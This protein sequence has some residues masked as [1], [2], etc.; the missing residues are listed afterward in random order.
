MRFLLLAFFLAAALPA[1]AQ[2]AAAIARARAAIQEALRQRPDDATLHFFMAR[3]DAASGD[4]R[5]ATEELA[6]AGKL[7]DGFLPAKPLGFE[8]VWDDPGFQAERARMEARLPRLDYAPNAVELEDRGLLPEGMAYDAPSES[9]FVGSIAE[10][11]IVRVSRD[12]TV[13][14]FTVEGAGMDNVLGLAV[15]APRRILYA[16][17]TSALTVE[18]RKSRRNAIFAYDVD[19][20]RLLHRMEIAGAIGLNDVA[21]AAGGRVFTTDSGSGAVYEVFP[22]KEPKA[23]AAPGELPGANGLAA[24]AD[25][26][27]LYVAHNTSIAIIDIARGGIT[28]RIANA[29]RENVAAIDGLYQWHGQLIGVQNV[30]TPGRVVLMS[31]SADGATITAVKTLLSHHHNALDEPTTGAPT[32][33]GFF[34]L[35]ATGAAHY[36][37]EGK[38]DD[39]GSVPKPTIVRVLLPR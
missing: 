1:P 27:R 21:V 6:T 38:I 31:L 17:S 23:W 28:K 18:G 12:G 33:R 5:A 4:A 34:L 8:K 7:G 16:V 22:D 9:F 20:G 10:R 11:K 25:A 36:N 13:K 2:D 39:P 37:A 19:S 3:V 26:S 32:D 30:T 24:S 35:A 14:D 15:D 29:T